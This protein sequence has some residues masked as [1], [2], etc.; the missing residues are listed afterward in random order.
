MQSKSGRGQVAER[1]RASH[2]PTQPVSNGA[3]GDGKRQAAAASE[4]AAVAAATLSSGSN[5]AGRGDTTPGKP[6]VV[7]RL[8]QAAE[9]GTLVVAYIYFL[10]WTF[11]RSALDKFRVS[12]E[13]AGIGPVWLLVRIVPIA[14]WIAVAAT[15]TYVLLS[16]STR[17]TWRAVWSVVV[18]VLAVPA[19]VVIASTLYALLSYVSAITIHLTFTGPRLSD[20]PRIFNKYSDTWTLWSTLV[21]AIGLI[22]ITIGCSAFVTVADEGRQ[23]VSKW[24]RQALD[25][26]DANVLQESPAAGPDVRP[27][28]MSERIRRALLWLVDKLDP[29]ES[30]VGLLIP[31]T[32]VTFVGH[33]LVSNAGTALGGYVEKGHV[34]SVFG[35]NWPKVDVYDIPGHTGARCMIELG[36]H[37][38]VYVFYDQSHKR[39]ERTSAANVDVQTPIVGSC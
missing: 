35:A 4:Q 25:W 23:H 9:L 38:A 39:V 5:R 1:R 33:S 2:V 28:P 14:A 15:A 29:R 19:G 22:G 12:P 21:V 7:R 11:F 37:S 17:R 16:L 18:G 34:V 6:E 10:G 27:D 26:L 30:L 20:F 32:V 13:D 8:G 36:E 24:L 3:A 31:V